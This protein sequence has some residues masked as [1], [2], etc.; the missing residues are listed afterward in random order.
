MSVTKLPIAESPVKGLQYLAY[1]LGIL[2]NYEECLPWF[3]SNYI[4]LTWSSDFTS[5]LTFFPNWFSTNPWLDVQVFKKDIIKSNHINIHNLIK[6]CID[7]RIYFYASFDEFY[8]PHRSAYGKSHFHHDFLIYGYDSI[9]KEYILLGYTDKQIIETTKISF[10]QFEE[11]F[12]LNAV[13][14]E[15]VHLIS[16]KED[17]K[18]D[19][20]LQLVYE[21][22]DDYLNSRNSSERGRMYGNILT[23]RVFGLDIYKYLREYFELLIK[24]NIHWDIRALHILYEHKKCMVLRLEYLYNNN[25]IDDHS[26]LYDNYK[27][28]ENKTLEMRNLQLKYI[29]THDKSYLSKIVNTLFE[30]EQKEKKLLENLLDKVHNKL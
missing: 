6:N 16:K 27:Y 29:I 12:F 23:N 21:M 25:Y 10:T 13:G 18:Y 30:I 9:Q 11:A 8:V 19:F 20:D 15:N 17:F 2:L 22:L 5:P 26:Y 4:Q 24:S 28:I 7:C 1:T 3:H 14:T